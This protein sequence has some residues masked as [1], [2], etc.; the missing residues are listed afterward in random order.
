ME[1]T[2]Y[3]RL[4]LDCAR[5]AFAE[6]EIPVGC[7]IVRNGTVIASGYN[8]R[9]AEH[10]ALSHAEIAAIHGACQALRNWRLSDCTLYVTLEPCPMCAGAILN[11]RIGTIV[12]GASEQTMGS[13][14]SVINLFEERYGFHPKIY[15]GVLEQEC[16][17]LMQDFFRNVRINDTASSDIQQY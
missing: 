3:M 8:R 2:D 7:V 5:Q 1:R 11:A 13:C 17:E 9:E 15:G 16:R 6:G 14:G 4:A 10:S 12:F